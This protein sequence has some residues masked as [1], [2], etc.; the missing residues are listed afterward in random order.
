MKFIFFT[1]LMLIFFNFLFMNFF[2]ILY[3]SPETYM[4][5]LVFINMLY[6]FWI[7]IPDHKIKIS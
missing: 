3:V 5:Y 4:S 6:I 1:L 7:I 2:S